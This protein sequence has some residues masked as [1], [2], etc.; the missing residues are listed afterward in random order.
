LWLVQ[1]A[2]L[3]WKGSLRL[4]LLEA[5]DLH[6]GLSQKLILLILLGRDEGNPAEWAG[7]ILGKFEEIESAL[8]AHLVSACL[9][10]Q[11]NLRDLGGGIG[12]GSWLQRAR[13]GVVRVGGVLAFRQVDRDLADGAVLLRAGGLEDG[14]LETLRKEGSLLG[15]ANVGAIVMMVLVVMVEEV[16]WRGIGIVLK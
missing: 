2:L 9:D 15:W 3:L 14:E 4:A 16:L 10:P 5:L 7:T 11:A 1:P 13:T 6:K 12:L 8:V